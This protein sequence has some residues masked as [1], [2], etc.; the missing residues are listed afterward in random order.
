M[1]KTFTCIGDYFRGKWDDFKTFLFADLFDD[2][3]DEARKT[4]AELDE[5]LDYINTNPELQEKLHRIDEWEKE[6]TQKYP[7]IIFF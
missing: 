5:L 1:I 3:T 2:V 4:C 7:W 6:Q